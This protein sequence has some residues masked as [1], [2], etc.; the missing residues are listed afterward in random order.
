MKFALDH[1]RRLNEVT[2]RPSDEIEL[3]NVI[4]EE[5]QPDRPASQLSTEN[6]K[7]IV[8]KTESS[9][10]LKSRASSRGSFYR[11]STIDCGEVELEDVDLTETEV[12]VSE[13]TSRFKIATDVHK[14]GS[15][16][17]SAERRNSVGG[18][19]SC[20]R[21]ISP[22]SLEDRLLPH[23]EAL[24]EPEEENSGKIEKESSILSRLKTFSERLSSSERDKNANGSAPVGKG[25]TKY[26][27]GT[28]QGVLKRSRSK[29]EPGKGRNL[30]TFHISR[31][32]ISFGI[33]S[34]KPQSEENML[35]VSERESP[36]GKCK[37]SDL[38]VVSP[39]EIKTST[40]FELLEPK[41]KQFMCS[42]AQP[43][44]TLSEK[45]ALSSNSILKHKRFS[46]S[47]DVLPRKNGRSRKSGGGGLNTPENTPSGSQDDLL[48]S[49]EESK[50]DGATKNNQ[51]PML[52][53]TK[54]F[55]P[56]AY[57]ESPKTLKKKHESARSLLFKSFSFRKK[58]PSKDDVLK[59]KDS[60]SSTKSDDK[61]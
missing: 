47:L 50:P 17:N 54:G 61:L 20:E 14:S 4:Q 11:S 39:V 35:S 28:L 25:S 33:S 23:V 52:N 22:K 6:S 59:N 31:P 9:L 30:R 45:C 41:K 49:S 24:T 37:A 44:P 5:E 48:V 27:Q 13:R 43:S 34:H 18:R 29:S 55:K 56:L 1:Y 38:N 8:T 2:K 57:H 53:R 32:R 3:P 15:R 12:D 46:L 7:R 19:S 16:R 26:K 60:D 36:K 40:S 58:S 21:T 51:Q 10:S 42:D